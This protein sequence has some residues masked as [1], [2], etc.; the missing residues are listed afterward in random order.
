[1]KFQLKNIIAIMAISLAFVSCSKD[2]EA[3]SGVGKLTVEFDNVYKTANFAF[4]T[5]YTNSNNEVVSITQAKYIVSN[6][7]LT[8][9]D[10]TIFTLPKSESYFIVDEAIPASTSLSLPNIP[11]GDY[12][13]IKFGIGVDQAQWE[14]GADGQGNFLTQAQTAGMMWNWTGGYKFVNFEG[15]FTSSSVTTATNFQVHTGKTGTAYNYT[16]VTLNF[17]DNA[18]VRTTIT[19][20]VHL[21][22]DLSKIIDGT[23]VINLSEQAA[24]MGGTKLTLVTEN[25]GS[26]FSVNH[27]HND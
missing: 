25:I 26:M 16:D 19:P 11:A 15:S 20:T 24:I 2:D 10:G 22:A 1:M 9:R 23:N 6:I 13:S 17:P 8:K 4:S 14:L 27:V 3:V 5:N 7:V 21:F 18:L 12:K